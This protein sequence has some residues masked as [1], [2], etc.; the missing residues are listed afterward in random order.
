MKFLLFLLLAVPVLAK[1]TPAKRTCRLLFLNAPPNA[2][3]EIY[4]YD[5]V[6][7]RKVELPSMNLSDVYPVS[8]DAPAVRLLAAPV[9]KP[10]ELPTGAP[11]AKLGE[12]VRDFFIIVAPDPK[13]K[14]VPLQMQ[15]IDAGGAKFGKGRM[16]WYNLTDDAIAGMLG[17]QKLALKP[18]SRAILEPPATGQE[19]YP[20]ELFYQAPGGQVQPISRTQWLHDPRSRML[21]FIHGGANGVAPQVTGFKDF[22]IEE[23]KKK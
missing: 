3:K 12:N 8:G 22:R 23:E 15:I 9:K 21:M 11:T 4:L 16:M 7:T 10:E 19:S 5:G 17:K 14:V 1:E 20:V 18:H 13:N 6:E 2:P